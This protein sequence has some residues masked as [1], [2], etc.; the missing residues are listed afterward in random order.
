MRKEGKEQNCNVVKVILAPIKILT[1]FYETCVKNIDISSETTMFCPASQTL[2]FSSNTNP[3]SK[4]S[5]VQEIGKSAQLLSE[6]GKVVKSNNIMAERTS[7]TFSKDSRKC[8]QMT[9]KLASIEEEEP[10]I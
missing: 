3:W 9:Q 7:T 1:S 4:I 2:S 6:K 10:L 5:Y 8:D